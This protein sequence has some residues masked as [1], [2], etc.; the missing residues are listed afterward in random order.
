LRAPRRSRNHQARRRRAKT[1][2]PS[3]F[4]YEQIAKCFRGDAD[5]GPE[6]IV[7][8]LA[9]I[10]NQITGRD[11][12]FIYNGGTDEQ[13]TTAVQ[14]WRNFLKNTPSAKLCSAG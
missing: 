6:K 7:D 8:A 4:A 12:G 9:A 3:H 13:R 2:R 10:L 1:T 5:Y 11:F 14:G